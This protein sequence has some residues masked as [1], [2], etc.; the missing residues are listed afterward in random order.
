MNLK[1]I[2]GY[3][4]ISSD[5]KSEIWEN[6]IFVV[7]TSFLLNLYRYEETIVNDIYSIC[8]KI[9]SRLWITKYAA[10]EYLRNR[11]TVRNEQKK[12]YKKAISLAEKVLTDFQKDSSDYKARHTYID[13]SEFEKSIESAIRNLKEHLI[14]TEEADPAN[15]RE[16]PILSKIHSFIEDRVHCEDDIFSKFSDFIQEAEKRFRI[17]MPPGYLDEK[18]DEVFLLDGIEIPKKYGD[19][20]IWK[21]IIGLS[22]KEGKNIIFITDDQKEDWWWKSAGRKLG[23]RPELI[24][25]FFQETGKQFLAYSSS[26]FSKA[27]S[28]QFSVEIDGSTSSRIQHINR[29]PLLS[30]DDLN[31][32]IKHQINRVNL[33]RKQTQEVIS[34]ICHHLDLEELDDDL[35]PHRN[36]GFSAFLGRDGEFAIYALK[37]VF[38]QG[39]SPSDL[40]KLSANINEAIKEIEISYLTH[41]ILGVVFD[42]GLENDPMRME[43]IQKMILSKINTENMQ[44]MKF[45][46]DIKTGKISDF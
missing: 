6:S 23:P 17:K 36:A 39:Q 5:D 7:D 34:L 10:I 37:V 31:I 41:G 29:T 13:T 15:L 33:K 3:Y 4:P 40:E 11:E 20:I 14:K 12:S 18:K 35:F 19:L 26:A 45:R 46:S 24:R 30:E 22:K 2:V 43:L 27:S 28:E 9:R 8:E 42:E 44:I 16:D 25:E 21:E 38:I 1:D 32:S